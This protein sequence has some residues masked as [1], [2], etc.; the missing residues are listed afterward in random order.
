MSNRKH[1]Q[2]VLACGACGGHPADPASTGIAS[3]QCGKMLVGVAPPVAR[4][5]DGVAWC[6]ASP[7]RAAP[8]SVI[9]PGDTVDLAIGLVAA[10]LATAALLEDDGFAE[11]FPCDVVFRLST[12]WT[13]GVF[14]DLDNDNDVTWRFAAWLADSGGRVVY[15]YGRDEGERDTPTKEDLYAR[16]SW[17]AVER[18]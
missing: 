18:R 10:G 13:L 4:D 15:E 9:S 12:G 6:V 16:W 17:S 2:W 11:P 8:L 14:T 5:E 3:C 7:K 1:D